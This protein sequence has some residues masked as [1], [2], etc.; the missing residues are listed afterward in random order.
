MSSPVPE[1][2]AAAA[3]APHGETDGP[4][5]PGTC[6]AL[7]PGEAAARARSL[8]RRTALRF[9]GDGLRIPFTD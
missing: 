8:G 3:S 7:A 1:Y 5:Y 9:R 2:P 4:R 6:R